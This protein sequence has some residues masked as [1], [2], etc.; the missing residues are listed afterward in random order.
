[1]AHIGAAKQL[2]V[3]TGA[4]L[5]AKYGTLQFLRLRRRRLGV[6][7]VRAVPLRQERPDGRGASL[8]RE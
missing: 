6:H 2:I 8:G 4:K 7:N 5:G 3:A 1:M